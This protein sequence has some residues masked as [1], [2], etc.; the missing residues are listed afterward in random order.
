M[1]AEPEAARKVNY[2]LLDRSFGPQLS[3]DKSAEDVNSILGLATAKCEGVLMDFGFVALVIV[4][5][6]GTQVALV[7][8][9]VSVGV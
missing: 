1:I 6:A 2:R 9:C 7:C 3:A 5:C 4:A 8:V